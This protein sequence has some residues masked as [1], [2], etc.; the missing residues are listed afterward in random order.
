MKA[1]L[2]AAD[3]DERLSEKLRR[4]DGLLKK[5]RAYAKTTL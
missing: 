5:W 3:G 4:F 1:Y 2:A